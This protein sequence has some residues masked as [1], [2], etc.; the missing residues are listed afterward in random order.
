MPSEPKVLHA[1]P[2]QLTPAIL[3]LLLQ[4]LIEFNGI[5]YRP[6]PLRTFREKYI[7]LY[8]GTADSPSCNSFLR[9]LREFYTVMNHKF[10][11]VL[12][13]CDGD[14]DGYTRHSQLTLWPTYPQGDYRAIL[15]RNH[16]IVKECPRL[17]IL[18]PNGMVVTTDGISRVE[19][20]NHVTFPWI[21]PVVEA[22]W[23]DD[24]RG[25]I[26]ALLDQLDLPL[27]S[28]VEDLSNGG[29]RFAQGEVDDH[30]HDL[31]PHDHALHRWQRTEVVALLFGELWCPETRELVRRLTFFLE[32]LN[33]RSEEF[34]NACPVYFLHT[35]EHLGKYACFSSVEMP[36]HSTHLGEGKQRAELLHYLGL[37]GEYPAICIIS[38][39]QGWVVPNGA[40]WLRRDPT[41]ICFPWRPREDDSDDTVSAATFANIVRELTEED[42]NEAFCQGP[43]CV[44]F[45]QNVHAQR[46]EALATLRAAAVDYLYH[47]RMAC[48]GDSEIVRPH[49]GTVD[50]G[51]LR[52][53][54]V[55]TRRSTVQSQCDVSHHLVDHKASLEHGH[56]IGKEDLASTLDHGHGIGKAHGGRNL[57]KPTK[58]ADKHEAV[59]GTAPWNASHEDVLA[60][61]TYAS[62]MSFFYCTNESRATHVLSKFC[63][64]DIKKLLQHH[65]WSENLASHDNEAT[66]V[67]ADASSRLAELR[68]MVK[69]LTEDTTATASEDSPR[70][71]QRRRPT[72]A[73]SLLAQEGRLDN[74]MEPSLPGTPSEGPRDD[75]GLET[76][77]APA[78]LLMD[79]PHRPK[80][81]HTRLND[82]TEQLLG[83]GRAGQ[84]ASLIIDFTRGEY[85]VCGNVTS[86]D[87][88]LKFLD[89]W[90]T[91]E[92]V[93]FQISLS[94]DEEMIKDEDSEMLR[95]IKANSD[96]APSL[97]QDNLP[98]AMPGVVI[99]IPTRQ[100]AECPLGPLGLYRALLNY[101]FKRCPREDECACGWPAP[102]ESLD[103]DDPIPS[104]L[105]SVERLAPWIDKL[106]IFG[107]KEGDRE[108]SEQGM[109]EWEPPGDGFLAELHKYVTRLTTADIIKANGVRKDKT[110]EALINQTDLFDD[111]LMELRQVGKEEEKTFPTVGNYNVCMRTAQT[112]R[113][114]YSLMLD[115]LS[116]HALVQHPPPPLFVLIVGDLPSFTAVPWPT[117][118]QRVHVEV[119][120]N[121]PA[122]DD[123]LEIAPLFS[124]TDWDA[125]LRDAAD[126]FIVPSVARHL[127]VPWFSDEVDTPSPV[128][129]ADAR[130]PMLNRQAT[131][132]RLS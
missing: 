116:Y 99:W 34:P 115:E 72:P 53:T 117:T 33:S 54:V 69:S 112:R 123:F 96:I 100:Q 1:L 50:F 46:G 88:I 84:G 26:C 10:E 74:F 102:G 17:V 48:N 79:T 92:L 118:L 59:H 65:L 111:G 42:L 29:A 28:Q 106:W 105:K 132:N 122:K 127:A 22:L 108:S 71:R 60:F 114:L 21:E 55:L 14:E 78:A 104:T 83:D 124:T 13:S 126:D 61:R 24:T 129:R 5:T 82:L 113:Q 39:Q 3:S 15:L 62:S 27:P 4:D 66:K 67:H 131:A 41:G 38:P 70:D 40:D 16:F 68:D 45:M 109:G 6:V 47:T 76:P 43:V 77:K 97:W 57:W 86:K 128:A 56:G 110:Q 85:Y 73:V 52:K 75:E 80:T 107:L 93:P 81:T 90:Y 12:V 11:C 103:H 32:N 49:Q 94:N 25:S 51:K 121:V 44:T 95:Q 87:T 63:S 130:R 20:G 35:E 91:G 37:S 36:F 9:H 8:F 23:G 30:D 64:W 31:H 89:A 98:K 101:A 125:W 7:G 18:D 120:G 58:T 119:V 19:D 2:K